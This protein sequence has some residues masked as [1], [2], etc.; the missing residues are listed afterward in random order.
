MNISEMDENMQDQSLG[1]YHQM[2]LAPEILFP[3][4]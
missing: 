1:F 3:P 4:S 2:P